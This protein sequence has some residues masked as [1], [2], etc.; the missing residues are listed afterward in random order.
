M[1][2]GGST[3]YLPEWSYSEEPAVGSPGK[4]PIS[5]LLALDLFFF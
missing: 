2:S 3:G 4:T 5:T 1:T